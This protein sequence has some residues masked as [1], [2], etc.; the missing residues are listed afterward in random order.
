[1]AN[2]YVEDLE[3]YISE[4]LSKA[5]DEAAGE[6]LDFLKDY[7]VTNWYNTYDPKAY[8]RTREFLESASKTETTMNN[9]N[10]IV[11]MLYFDTS[12]IY[13]RYFGPWKLNQHASFSGKDVS[14]SIPA[15]IERGNPNIIGRNGKP[16]GSMEA[17]INMLE[18]DFHKKVAQK[19]R[20]QGLKINIK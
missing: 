7:I 3:L 10:E 17:T 4:C 19:L 16:L 8:E 6:A 1:M 9:K 15:W 13:P 11:C 20:A 14:K 18:K 2:V 12:K 5:V